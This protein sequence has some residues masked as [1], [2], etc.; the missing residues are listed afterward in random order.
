[1]C[2]LD[3]CFCLLKF[4]YSISL[5]LHDSEIAIIWCVTVGFHWRKYTVTFTLSNKIL[6][7][8]KI[9]EDIFA[10]LEMQLSKC[11][12]AWWV[13]SMLRICSAWLREGFAVDL[14]KYNP[15][16]L[17]PVTQHRQSSWSS[18]SGRQGMVLGAI[19]P[20]HPV[21]VGWVVTLKPT[22]LSKPVYH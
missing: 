21:Q 17:N 6:N 5:E 10:K 8:S 11:C 1:M 7:A 20:A 13:L 15:F 16:P 22:A 9:M 12:T 18:C 19:P 3:D 2:G 4:S 14:V